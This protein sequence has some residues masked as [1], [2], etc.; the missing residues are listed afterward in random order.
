MSHA[1]CMDKFQICF[2]S[3]PRLQARL[4]RMTIELMSCRLSVATIERSQIA[5][6]LQR[7]NCH[8]LASADDTLAQSCMPE[9]ARSWQQM[10]CLS[11]SALDFQLHPA[12]MSSQQK[13]EQMDKECRKSQRRLHALNDII[14]RHQADCWQCDM[15]LAR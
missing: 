8:S 15:A 6:Y 9:N 12:R 3:L 14:H 10:S 2:P 13:F 1:S 7:S 4:K 11:K 5:Y